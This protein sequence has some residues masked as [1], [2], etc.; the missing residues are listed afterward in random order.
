M[1][2]RKDSQIVIFDKFRLQTRYKS[3][4]IRGKMHLFYANGC[5]NGIFPLSLQRVFHGIRFKVM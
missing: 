3:I 4:T 5:I 2:R 1:A